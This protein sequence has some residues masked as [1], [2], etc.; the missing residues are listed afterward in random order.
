MIENL[1]IT[2]AHRSGTSWV[3]KMIAAS[4]D[5]CLRDEELFN[6]VSEIADFPFTN[7]YTHICEENEHLYQNFIDN[8]VN[9]NYSMSGALKRIQSSRDLLRVLKRKGRSLYRKSN[10]NN[11]IFIEP[12]GL[13][14]AEWFANKFNSININEKKI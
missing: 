1:F 7:M 12:I 3:G 13:F 10:Y 8:M 9:N 6:C 4:G 14:S 2:G 11:T 5:Y